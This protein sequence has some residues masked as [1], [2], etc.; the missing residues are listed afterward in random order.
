MVIYTEV[1]ASPVRGA[2]LLAGTFWA[3]FLALAVADAELADIAQ[4]VQAHVNYPLGYKAD[5][6]LAQKYLGI[7]GAM[8]ETLGIAPYPG[9]EETGVTDGIG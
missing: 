9:G 7:T 3:K 4:I 2:P 6:I 5:F 8:V 1:L